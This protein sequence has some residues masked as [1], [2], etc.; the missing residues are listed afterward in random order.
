MEN[1]ITT[2][3][4]AG[5]SNLIELRVGT[6]AYSYVFNGEAGYLD[7]ALASAT[8]VAQVTG[9]T[10]WHI[11]ADEPRVLD[12]NEEFKS[13]AQVISYYNADPYRSSDHDPVVIELLVAGDLDNDGDV[14]N[15]D[16]NLFRS[17]LGHCS[18][19]SIY[20]AEAD[21]DDNACVNYLDYR[22]WYA[23]YRAYRTHSGL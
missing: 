12:Y 13:P 6:A 20:L 3:G 14:D 2:L 5:Y 7:H 23:H 9:I 19:S 18:G 4:L 8:L 11:N 1:P 17:K 16:Y 22:I 15:A 21:Y 10:E